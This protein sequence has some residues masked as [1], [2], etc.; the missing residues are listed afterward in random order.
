[1]YVQPSIYDY[2]HDPR[3][4]RRDRAIMARLL[5]VIDEHPPYA[6]TSSCSTHPLGP[7]PPG[8]PRFLTHE[9][10]GPK[11]ASTA[12]EVPG[13][14]AGLAVHELAVVPSSPQVQHEAARVWAELGRVLGACGGS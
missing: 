9:A 5:T 14:S 3:H 2:V 8:V 6:H 7:P 11:I 13:E 10:C 12:L 1:L 4:P